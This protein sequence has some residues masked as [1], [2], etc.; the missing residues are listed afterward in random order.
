MTL[1]DLKQKNNLFDSHTHLGF[2]GYKK[3][4]TEI[5][6]DSIAAEVT[7]LFDVSVDLDTS[8]DNLERVKRNKNV[9]C[10]VGI[11]PE[12]VIPGSEM[13]KKFDNVEQWIEQQ[14]SSLDE[15]ISSNL[16]EISGIGET[17]IDLHHLRVSGAT[18]EELEESKK[19]QTILYEEQLKLAQKYN[20]FLSIHSRGAEAY[21]L[22]VLKKYNVKGIF[23]S[24][25]G[26]FATA[27]KVLEH[28]CGLGVNGIVT[29]KNS[30]DLK[31]IYKKLIGQ[32]PNDVSP[33]F[34]YQK[35]IF[36]ETD[37]PFLAPEGK[38]GQINESANIRIIFDKFVEDLRS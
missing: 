1:D 12:V 24:Y 16:A 13:Y 31:L 10:L 8:K 4:E 3:T 5:I 15:L 37:A 25:T 29:F 7:E 20:L 21:C 33:N 17:G 6:N 14:I 19:I 9:K 32:I 28:G 22:E 34:F 11:D 30:H 27:E 23:H 38:R 36:F 35:G 2:P 26:D 18:E